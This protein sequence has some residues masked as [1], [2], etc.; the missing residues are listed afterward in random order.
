MTSFTLVAAT[1]GTSRH[2]SLRTFSL[3]RI[4]R[5]SRE[6]FACG[7]PEWMRPSLS[8]SHSPLA[9]EGA[10][11]Q[12]REWPRTSRLGASRSSHLAG[13]LGSAGGGDLG[14]LIQ[15]ICTVVFWGDNVCSQHLS[16]AV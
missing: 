4:A 9:F 10:G 2:R 7:T 5:G 16:R 1:P 8:G 12:P 6:E 14:S 3:W 13:M 11:H 15:R